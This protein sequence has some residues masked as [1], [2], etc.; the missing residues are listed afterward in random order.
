LSAVFVNST[1]TQDIKKQL[2]RKYIQYPRSLC[3]K[4]NAYLAYL[5][6]LLQ[7]RTEYTYKPH[8]NT[9]TDTP[10]M[11]SHVYTPQTAIK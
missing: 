9:P 8:I 11:S 5:P 6:L 10:C 1:Y 2:N 7:M 4:T 3:L